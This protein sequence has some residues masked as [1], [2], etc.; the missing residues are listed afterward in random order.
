MCFRVLNRAVARLTLF[1]KQQD[2]EIA[3]PQRDVHVQ[4]H[5]LPCRG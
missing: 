4:S 3:F 1:E 2:L 5:Q